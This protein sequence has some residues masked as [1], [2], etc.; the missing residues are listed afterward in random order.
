MMPN[1]SG[2]LSLDISLWSYMC[3]FRAQVGGN[4]VSYDL[5]EFTKK[6]ST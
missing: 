4:L 1:Y 2:N 5:G 3:K 6:W